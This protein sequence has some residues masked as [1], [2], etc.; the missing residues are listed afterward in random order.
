MSN[1]SKQIRGLIRQINQGFFDLL[2]FELSKYDITVPQWLVIRCL[3]DGPQSMSDISRIV[4]LTN[5]T[6]TGIVDRLERS[7][8]VQR[9][10]D[11]EDRRVVWVKRTDRLDQL[12]ESIPVLQDSYFEAFLEGIS[13]DQTREIL[14][15]L[16]LLAEHILDKVAQRKG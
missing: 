10:R 5:S 16:H 3:G 15:S 14:I 9:V 11:E 1:A 2:S 4:D 8:Y 7:G 12:I 13:E 6:I